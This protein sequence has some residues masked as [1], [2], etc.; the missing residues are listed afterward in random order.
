MEAPPLERKLIA[1]LSS[2]A[3]GYSRLMEDDEAGALALLTERRTVIDEAIA[4][5]RGRIANTAGDSVL[6][7]FVSIFDAVN[8]AVDA[9]AALTKINAPLP[10]EK[11]MEFRIGLNIGDV[12]AKDGDIFGDGVNIAARVQSLAEPG[13]ICVTRGVRDHIRYKLPFGF[14]DLG[15]QTVKNISHPVRVFRL[16]PDGPPPAPPETAP[17]VEPAAAMGAGAVPVVA[18]VDPKTVELALWDSIKDSD[19]PEDLESYLGQYPDGTFA[20]VA[21]ARLEGEPP[22]DPTEK[23]VELAFWNTV[24]DSGN[25]EMFQAYLEKYPEGEFKPLA[26]IRLKELSES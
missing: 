13:G 15:E 8:C 1:V 25:P 23:E 10:P 11:R 2:D 4:R 18:A 7:E 12:M 26:E 5:Y 9:Q 24:K 16:L 3:V 21:R 19:R 17:P 14:D 22:P 6:A 20:A